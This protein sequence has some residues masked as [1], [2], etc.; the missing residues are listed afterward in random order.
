MLTW[1][2][3]YCT[4]RKF[5]AFYKKFSCFVNLLTIIN[6][7]FEKEPTIMVWIPCNCHIF[8]KDKFDLWPDDLHS[9]ANKRLKA[10]PFV[11]KE[12]SQNIFYIRSKKSSTVDGLLKFSFPQITVVLKE[13][14]CIQ[15]RKTSNLFQENNFYF[16]IS[17]ILKS[18]IVKTAF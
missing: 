7:Y 16:F 5:S 9:W 18:N 4:V 13:K 10:S 12:D 17:Q 6:R 3:L 2:T 15:K 14:I 8:R 1:H 11:Q